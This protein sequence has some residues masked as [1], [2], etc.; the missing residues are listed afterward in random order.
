[1]VA[2]H[3]QEGRG[4]VFT[5]HELDMS[6]ES[7]GRELITEKSPIIIFPAC[8]GQLLFWVVLIGLIVV[9]V[10]YCW[11]PDINKKCIQQ[12]LYQLVKPLP[13]LDVCLKTAQTQSIWFLCLIILFIWCSKDKNV[14]KLK[15]L[16]LARGKEPKLYRKQLQLTAKLKEKW[17]RKIKRNYRKV[18][19][20]ESK[21]MIM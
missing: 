6:A 14:Y 5:Q 4:F 20:T 18:N 16:A 11:S 10:V 13:P 3:L 9:C 17:L 1:M 19:T 21:I 7:C 8:V 12:Y 2:S 15:I